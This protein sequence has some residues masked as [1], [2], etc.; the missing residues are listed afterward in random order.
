MP[1]TLWNTSVTGSLDPHLIGWVLRLHFKNCR[2]S[3]RLCSRSNS[4]LYNR[5]VWMGKCLI[6]FFIWPQGII[7]NPLF[8]GA[9][10]GLISILPN[11]AFN[12]FSECSLPGQAAD[13]MI[14]CSSV[15]EIPSA[16]LMFLQIHRGQHISKAMLWQCHMVK[17][18][19]GVVVVEEPFCFTF[20][21]CLSE[22]DILW[23][24][25]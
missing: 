19:M 18:L 4:A 13:E 14:Y 11:T 25:W 1:Q 9:H 7:A 3:Q 21:V 23:V 15:K 24:T 22:K 20:L 6:F 5:V 12:Y 2:F 17:L 16:S 8:D 10:V